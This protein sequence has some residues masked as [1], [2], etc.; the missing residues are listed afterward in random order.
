[1]SFAR[2]KLTNSA[3]T[4]TKDLNNNNNA[5]STN[6]VWC[7]ATHVDIR[8]L[9]HRIHLGIKQTVCYVE[10]GEVN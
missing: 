2:L 8:S 4:A 3:T 5:S 6:H 7:S 9:R 10:L 1:M